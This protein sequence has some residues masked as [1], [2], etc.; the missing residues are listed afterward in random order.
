M[1]AASDTAAET[2]DSPTTCTSTLDVL[3]RRTSLL[4]DR[5][6]AAGLSTWRQRTC[7]SVTR[8][9][10][11]KR[12]SQGGCS[13]LALAIQRCCS[14]RKFSLISTPFAEKQRLLLIHTASTSVDV[15]SIHI[16]RPAVITI[17]VTFCPVWLQVV[18]RQAIVCDVL[19]W[20][21]LRG[22]TPSATLIG[23][24]TTP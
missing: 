20:L 2:T 7:N 9:S 14:P 17:P 24:R 6:A 5:S 11:R 19:W 21:F 13:L 10:L 22:N 23:C 18:T 8:W 12:I 3:T 16:L 1:Q 4:V 15:V